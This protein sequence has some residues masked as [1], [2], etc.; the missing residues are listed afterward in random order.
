M[1][2]FLLQQAFFSFFYSS[3]EGDGN[4]VVNA[5]YFGFAATSFCF[6]CNAEGIVV[7]AFYFN[8]A[9]TSFFSLLQRRRRCYR[10]LLF[11]F[12]C[13]KKKFVTARKALL[14]SPSLL[15]QAFF[16]LFFVVARKALLPSPFGLVA[17]VKKATTKLLPSSLLQAFFFVRA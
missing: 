1:P 5:F 17:T 7:V 14:S 13:N 11:W 4:I 3:V 12:C 8:F 15:Q 16:F 6:C 2:I 9:T 10:R